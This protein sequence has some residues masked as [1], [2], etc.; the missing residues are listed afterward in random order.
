MS[1][2]C[3][4]AVGPKRSC[5][6]RSGAVIL[7]QPVDRTQMAKLLTTGKTDLLE[8]FISNKNG[9][10]F[11]A[12]LIFKNGKV[13]FEFAPREAKSS[14]KQ[15]KTRKPPVKLDFAGQEPLGACP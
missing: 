11:K 15:S 9:R 8:K 13:G 2:V 6:F 7:Q 12:H 14:A 4:N 10:P 1:Y 3:G 5:D